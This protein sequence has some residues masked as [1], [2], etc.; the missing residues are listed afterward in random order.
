M[1]AQRWAN[2][3]FL[4]WPVEPA[5]VAASCPPGVSAGHV[6]RQELR[7]ARPVP[8]ARRRPGR[9]PAGPVLR[10]L[11]RDERAALLGRRRRPQ[12]HRLPHAGGAPAVH[13]AAGPVEP[14][15]AL[16]LVEDASHPR[17]RPVAI[18]T[19]TTLAAADRAQPR[20]PS[21]SAIRSEPTE[22]EVWLT[23]RWGLHTRVA[24][25]TIWVPN[26][27]GTVAA[28][29]RRADRPGRRSGRRGG[30]ADAGPM[31]RPLFSPG[32]RTTFGC[33]R[34]RLTLAAPRRTVNSASEQRRI[35]AV[36]GVRGSGR[37][38][39]P[40]PKPADRATARTVGT[41]STAPTPSPSRS[42]HAVSGSRPSRSSSRRWLRSG[43]S[44]VTTT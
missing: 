9:P 21:G 6:R 7:R 24:G 16:H 35:P 41:S 5:A 26:Q 12:R 44:E 19:R 27:H 22:L 18:P 8:D 29:V 36:D 13:R 28:A 42:D 32:V 34:R 31:L 14:R 23:S 11:L 33:R 15:A 40:S 38:R 1:S 4:H 20:S 10:R 37:P 30:S 17:R 39:R 25:R 43:D 2:L 3:T